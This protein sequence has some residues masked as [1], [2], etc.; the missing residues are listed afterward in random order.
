MAVA[1][2]AHKPGL[3]KEQ[4]MEVFK[5]HFQG[6]YE[7]IPTT[8]SFGADEE[9]R[10]TWMVLPRDFIVQKN[11]FVGCGVQ[12]QQTGNETKFVYAGYSPNV[13]ARALTGA[14]LGILSYLLWNGITGEVRSLI[15]SAPE[16]K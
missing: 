10:R 7:V 4:A 12:L 6:K 14:S 1:K 15:E 9:A 3:T 11:N 8:K 16:F 2:I 5:K 13:F